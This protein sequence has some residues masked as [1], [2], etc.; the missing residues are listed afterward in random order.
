MSEHTLNV[1][2]LGGYG[3][4]GGRLAR[5]L[6]D[7]PA[8]LLMIAGRSL[9][10]A[11]RFCAAL[12]GVAGRMP[13]AL[14]RDRD[15]A[16]RLHALRPDVVVDATGPFQAYGADPYRVVR[17]A[18]AAGAHYLDLADGSAFVRNVV[19]FDSA[20][21]GAGK[22]V[23][24]GASSFPVLTAAVVR[25][26][27]AGLAF[28][29]TIEGGIAPSPYAGVGGNVIRAVASYA[30]RRV[31]IRRDSRVADGYPFTETRRYTIAPP[32]AVP[33]EPRT[34]SLVD[35]PDLTLL[36]DLWP[37]AR[38]IWMGV[39]PVPAM[40]HRLLRWLAHGVRLRVLPSLDRLAPLLHLT[41]NTLRWGEDR[42]GMFVAIEGR[43]ADGRSVCRSWHMVAEADA[44]PL[45]PS[46]AVEAI[47]RNL[48][49]GRPP[50]PGARAATQELGLDDYAASFARHG[51]VSGAR[52][53]G[54]DA[55]EA[56]PLFQRILGDAW[57]RLPPAV[58]A[59]HAAPATATVT[60]S[61][62]V[63]TGRNWLARVVRRLFGF[64]AA[65]SDTPLRIT[66]ERVGGV[67]KWQRD[68]G[69]DKFASVLYPGRGRFERLLCERF[70]PFVF[71]VAL[72]LENDRLRYIVRG[73]S[74]LGIPLP[75]ALAPLGETFE[76]DEAGC[77]HFDVEID[78]PV[79]GA[80]VRY[81]GRLG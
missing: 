23:L 40:L 12:G 22:F 80:I 78:A 37:D 50:L 53:A 4:F 14:D 31:D 5:L 34:F 74:V 65:T 58:R 71:G 11:E 36:A 43:R 57:Q 27:A 56:A 13:V 42:G 75:R 73:W 51:I 25:Q 60:G 2:I 38:S 32:G 76:C 15:I 10:E 77:F 48:L 6:A 69:G 20:A 8:L 30:G 67:E 21:R 18:L 26:L 52:D 24:S 64:P 49:R 55:S 70:G 61:A 59:L 68:F 9:D 47:V 3:T 35:V 1:L 72:V 17:A 41:T 16:A 45:I 66:F 29:D 44:G 63:V 19:Q 79:V 46:M 33:L 54:E 28:V 62:L 39:A 81:A 7:E